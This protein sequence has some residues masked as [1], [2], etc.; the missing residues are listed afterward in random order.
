[1]SYGGMYIAFTESY[2]LDQYDN[3]QEMADNMW[4]WIQDEPEMN[5]I[6]RGTL[7]IGDYK[8]YFVSYY[9]DGWYRT[10]YYLKENGNTLFI[11][12]DGY[13]EGFLASNDNDISSILQSLEWTPAHN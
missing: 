12:V 1:S 13:S 7:T 5:P 10:Q 11:F 4:E 8:A 3:T 6:N 9:S 2:W